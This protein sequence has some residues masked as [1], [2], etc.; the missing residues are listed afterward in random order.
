[1]SGGVL[2]P[3]IGHEGAKAI[4]RAAL[5]NGDTNVLLVGPPASGKTVILSQIEDHL[6]GAVYRDMAG[7]SERKL[8]DTL[9]SN[10]RYLLMDELDAARNQCYEALTLPMEQGRVTKDVTGESYDVSIDTQFFAACNDPADLPAH[11]VSRFTPI[12]FSEYDYP[13]YVEV[14]RR[15]LPESVEWVENGEEAI[16]VACAVTA[17]TGEK[18]PRRARDAA[19]LAGCVD[20]VS[21]IAAAMENPD[22]AVASDPITPDEIEQQERNRQDGAYADGQTLPPA[23]QWAEQ[24]CPHLGEPDAGNM[25]YQSGRYLC[26][27][28]ASIHDAAPDTPYPDAVE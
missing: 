12:E 20:R 19:R 28:C 17:A 21:G 25:A 24:S 15:L 10:P 23:E 26:P 8:R 13:E 2:S 16:L 27:D 1:M 18:N 7:Y 22:A 9:A 3:L 11:T 4:V 5:R 14:C 6:N